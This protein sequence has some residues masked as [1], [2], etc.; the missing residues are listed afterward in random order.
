MNTL[1]ENMRLVKPYLIPLVI[2]SVAK[3]STNKLP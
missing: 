1:Y 3:I 2:F